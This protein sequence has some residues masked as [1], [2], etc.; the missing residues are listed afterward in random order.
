MTLRR[1]TFLTQIAFIL[2]LLLPLNFIFTYFLR[3]AYKQRDNQRMEQAL[4]RASVSIKEK[5][6]ELY[7]VSEIWAKSVAT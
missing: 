1:K 5:T 6:Q 3:E 4:A 7:E 2:A